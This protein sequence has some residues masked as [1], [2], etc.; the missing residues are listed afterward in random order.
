MELWFLN[1]A[2]RPILIDVCMTF[3]KDSL[4]GCQV[5]EPTRFCD[6]QNDGRMDRRPGKYNNTSPNPEVC[7]G[8]MIQVT[9]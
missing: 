2:H 3:R 4:N 1:S 8:I 6:R 5:I 7:G 9:L